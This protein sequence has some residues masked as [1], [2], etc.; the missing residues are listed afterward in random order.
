MTRSF[1]LE[2]VT[3]FRPNPIIQPANP[4]APGL[5]LLINT[6]VAVLGGLAIKA[7][8]GATAK[9]VPNTIKQSHLEK[10]ASK[11]SQKRRG[12]VSPKKT[13]AGRTTPLEHL[14]H[15]GTPPLTSGLNI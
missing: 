8:K 2:K 11:F 10:S 3:E 15:L 9:E 13:T 6:L 1:G 4:T 7:L 14:E 12:N 5:V